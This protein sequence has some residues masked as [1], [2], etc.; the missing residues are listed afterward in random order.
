MERERRVRK[1][2]ECREICEQVNKERMER[3]HRVK[4]E[5]ESGKC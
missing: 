2:R 5:K 4:I 1:W 3:K